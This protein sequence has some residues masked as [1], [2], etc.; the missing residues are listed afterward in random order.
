MEIYNRYVRHR[1]YRDQAALFG[2]VGLYGAVQGYRYL[3]NQYNRRRNSFYGQALK[4]AF[5]SL[6]KNNNK[7]A[8]TKRGRSRTRTPKSYKRMNYSTPSR[9][10]SRSR[11]PG[12]RSSSAPPKYSI[13]GGIYTPRARARSV[14]RLST[15]S[16]S[17]GRKKFVPGGNV[18]YKGSFNS[19]TKIFGLKEKCLTQGIVYNRETSS[20]INGLGTSLYVGHCTNPSEF[21]S[22]VLWLCI[23]KKLLLM[24]GTQVND[25]QKPVPNLV[26]G[27]IFQVSYKNGYDSGGAGAFNYLVAGTPTM[28]DIASDISQYFN[29]GLTPKDQ[30]Q[31]DNIVFVPAAAS[32]MKLT[33]LVLR[34]ARVVIH[35]VSNLTIQNRTKSDETDESA[36][37]VDNQPLRGFSYFGYGT[38]TQTMTT[39]PNNVKEFV[40]D[41]VYGVL[42]KVPVAS[43]V[44]LQEPPSQIHF[45]NVKKSGSQNMD[46]GDVKNSKLIFNKTISVNSLQKQIT[47]NPDRVH[48]YHKLGK[49]KFFGFEKMIDI[50]F[51][52]QMSVAWEHNLNIGM[53]IIPGFEK[54]SSQINEK[55]Y[56]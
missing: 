6:K 14:S 29:A 21:T 46:V 22:D 49:F 48:T 16:L 9:S 7:M 34:N 25:T 23:V 52:Q 43:E 55:Y 3:R 10:R 31:F 20:V 24:M 19:T 4:G 32:K 15:A 44:Y 8:P 33:R 1:P 40:C 11:P 36:D 2:G 51:S 56:I 18:G 26:A 54:Y 42:S 53:Y 13:T 45:G 50:Q 39:D 5:H 35:S 38:G 17:V 41:D 28:V 37:Q 12:L 47:V 27:D 30:V